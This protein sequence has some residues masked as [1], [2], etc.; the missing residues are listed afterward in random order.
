MNNNE[1]SHGWSRILLLFIVLSIGLLGTTEY[2]YYQY[3]KLANIQK[4]T[5]ILPQEDI[6][7]IIGNL[8]KSILLPKDEKPTI[9]TVDDISKLNNQAFFKNAVNGNKVIIFPNSGMAILYDVKSKLILNV[10]PVN[11]S[12]QPTPTISQVRVALRNGTSKAGLTYKF[13]TI[14]KKLFSN[15]NVIAKDQS[16]ITEYEKTFVVVLNNEFINQ[17]N[18]I[19]TSL[20]SKVDV[21]PSGEYKPENVDILIILGK[22]QI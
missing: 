12:P 16:E 13:E 2:F 8:N 10:G 1:N 17:A 14:V 9:A 4:T 21:L 15:C 7:K 5:N 19:A 18:Q 6:D 20:N 11:F 3:N 22:D